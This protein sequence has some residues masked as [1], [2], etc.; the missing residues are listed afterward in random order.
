MVVVQLY[1][2]VFFAVFSDAVKNQVSS[3]RADWTGLY[4]QEGGAAG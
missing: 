2:H 3:I 1:F 4:G